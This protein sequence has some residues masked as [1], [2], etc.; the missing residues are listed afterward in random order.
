M[1]IKLEGRM[2]VKVVEFKAVRLCT[3]EDR[4]DGEQCTC[5]PCPRF[6]VQVAVMVGTDEMIEVLIHDARFAD[7]RQAAQLAAK[8]AKAHA[9]NSDH[10]LWHPS[11]VSPWAFVHTAPTAQPY[12]V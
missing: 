5:R 9:L 1:Q 12:A 7:R 3:D 2:Q 10:W 6:A 11:N 8:V 4:H